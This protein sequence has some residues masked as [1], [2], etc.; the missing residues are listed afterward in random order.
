VNSD[1]TYIIYIKKFDIKKWR[2]VILL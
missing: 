2:Q 1:N